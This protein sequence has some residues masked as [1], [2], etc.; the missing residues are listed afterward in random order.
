[1][2]FRAR[3]KKRREVFERS[4]RTPGRHART[5]ARRRTRGFNESRT[6]ARADVS[7]DEVTVTGQARRAF[8]RPTVDSGC[9]ER[10]AHFQVQVQSCRFDVL[11]GD[12]CAE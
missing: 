10:G 1:M 7:S 2:A 8:C 6:R 12:D 5:A 9:S 4:R 11:I 3:E